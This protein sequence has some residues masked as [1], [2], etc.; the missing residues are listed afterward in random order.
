M[1]PTRAADR[2]DWCTSSYRKKSRGA[3]AGNSLA[4]GGGVRG[5]NRRSRGGR[6]ALTGP[7]PRGAWSRSRPIAFSPPSARGTGRRPRRAR[8][9]AS[10]GDAPRRARAASADTAPA[11]AVDAAARIRR[12]R[13]SKRRARFYRCRRKTTNGGYGP[14]GWLSDSGRTRPPPARARPHP[15]TH[16]LDTSARRGERPSRTPTS[17]STRARTASGSPSLTATRPLRS[18]SSERLT[19]LDTPWRSTTS[20]AC[21][22][23]S[24]TPR[25]ARDRSR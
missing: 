1:R 14:K 7:A 22:S 8:H 15:P 2:L 9:R 21:A 4:G 11:D 17:H 24:R 12:L 10:L 20:R 18:R 3:Y 6:V 19:H 5:R 25:M 23:V 13:T 16:V